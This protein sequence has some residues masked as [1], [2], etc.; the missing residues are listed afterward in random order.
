MKIL[1]AGGC[2]FV[3]S[4]L[5]IHLKKQG[6]T[7]SSVDNLQRKGSKY[8]LNRIREFGIY[9]T[10]I[11]LSKNSNFKKLKKYNIIIDC[12]AEPSVEASKK[13]LR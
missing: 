12:C 11:D 7:V 3:G 4:N 6:Y 10:K 1:I 8:N 2:G 9:N 5:C 13:I